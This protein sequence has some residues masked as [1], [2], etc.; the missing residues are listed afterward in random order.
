VVSDA[1]SHIATDNLVVFVVITVLGG[2][3]DRERD[4]K[5]PLAVFVQAIGRHVRLVCV[6]SLLHTI[7][8]FRD[9]NNCSSDFSEAADHTL[10]EEAAV[11]K[12]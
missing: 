2:D 5:F 12:Q 9:M 11:S 4:T 6:E 3:S 10:V 7:S 8:F 1:T